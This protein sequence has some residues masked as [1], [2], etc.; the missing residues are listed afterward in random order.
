MP[1]EPIHTTPANSLTIT[2]PETTEGNCLV[3]CIGSY[4]ASTGA[5]S[6]SGI[7]LGGVADNFGT[8]PL[9][10]AHGNDGFGDYNDA[11]IWADPDC[12]GGQTSVVISGSNL[13]VGSGAGGVVVY[14]VPDLEGTIS[15]LLDQSSAGQTSDT[16]S[17]SY[18][19]GTTGETDSNSEIVFGC[20]S[21]LQPLS[22]EPSGY[23]NTTSEDVMVTGW[24]SATA[25][26]TFSYAGTLSE[27]GCWAA[28]VVTLKGS[29]PAVSGTAALA[30]E[31]SLS[32]AGDNEGSAALGAVTALSAM[33]DIKAAATLAATSS[34]PGAALVSTAIAMLAASSSLT[35][36]PSLGGAAVLAA[37]ASV[38]ASGGTPGAA[39]M[40]AGSG[41]TAEPST[42][43]VYTTTYAKAPDYLDVTGANQ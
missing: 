36:A 23:T 13:G 21:M 17:G 29:I 19:S 22:T 7:T 24:Q 27:Y 38:E 30:A 1:L 39:A 4:N 12:A 18:T 34:L 6:V 15:A 9:K 2:I 35:G 43:S 3:V 14:E 42:A 10:A 25:E 16:Y 11:F 8:L 40:D 26:G 28:V 41:L 33:G 32:A 5:G 31:A 37:E 20:A